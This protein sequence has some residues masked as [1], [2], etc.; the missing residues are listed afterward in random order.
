METFGYDPSVVGESSSPAGIIVAVLIGLV[1]LLIVSSR[2]RAWL[3]HFFTLAVMMAVWNRFK[4]V[5]TTAV[6][7]FDYEHL[8]VIAWAI[9]IGLVEF[10]GG[11]I[12]SATTAALG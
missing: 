6:V 4:V 11:L 12:S 10:L 9:D 2:F 8:G 7:S 1:V 3:F 5:I